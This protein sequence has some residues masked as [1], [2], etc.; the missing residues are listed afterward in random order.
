MTIKRVQVRLA[1]IQITTNRLMGAAST[2]EDA[3]RQHDLA[4]LNEF[5]A[6]E[7]SEPMPVGRFI[8]LLAGFNFDPGGEFDLGLFE[9]DLRSSIRF[10]SDTAAASLIKIP[11]EEPMV[12]PEQLA[13]ALLAMPMRAH[14][15]PVSL[16]T[17]LQ[18][19]KPK[20]EEAKPKAPRAKPMTD[21]IL[22][23]M[24]KMDPADLRAIPKKNLSA[25]FKASEDT[26]RRARDTVL[27]E[28][29][30]RPNQAKVG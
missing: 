8:H 21:P 28:K 5:W 30:K 10:A 20:A 27:E 1:E 12:R 15:I 13:R 18:K 11:G 3:V 22:V 23:E 17:F 29:V 26:C 9:L 19:D 2:D 4:G 16:R 24:R 25:K 14:L 6:I 7:L